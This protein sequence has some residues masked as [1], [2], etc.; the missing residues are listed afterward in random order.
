MRE[1]L[2]GARTMPGA[3]LRAFAYAS[4]ARMTSSQ[5]D[6]YRAKTFALRGEYMRRARRDREREEK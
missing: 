6:P 4:W 2:P 3:S 5:K 1:T